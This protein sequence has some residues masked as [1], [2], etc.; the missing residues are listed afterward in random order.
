MIYKAPWG[1]SHNMLQIKAVRDVSGKVRPGFGQYKNDYNPGLIARFFGAR[2]H[3]AGDWWVTD[4][5]E[6]HPSTEEEGRYKFAVDVWE[7]SSYPETWEF[8]KEEEKNDFLDQF[9]ALTLAKCNFK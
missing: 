3:K 9:N 2:S 1:T 7:K 4:F 6:D 8:D 5:Y